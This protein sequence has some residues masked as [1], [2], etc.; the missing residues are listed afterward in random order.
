MHVLL[1][2][3]SDLRHRVEVIRA[4]G[5]REKAELETR[6]FLVHDFVHY[7][8]E[9]ISGMTSGF[10]GM[11]ASGAPLRQLNDADATW[12]PDS[13]IG[14]AESV[15]GPMQGV[16]KGRSTA[17]SLLAGLEE[18]FTA[19]GKQ[20]PAWVTLKFIDQVHAEY[21]RLSGAWKA[22]PFQGQMVLVWP[23]VKLSPKQK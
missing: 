23:N 2:K 4:D 8:V 16:M 7:A 1:T 15:C 18:M 17:A 13:Q 22:T 6:S 5:T 3:L 14:L 11:L 21:A 19:T 12:D 20:P 10:F 9:G